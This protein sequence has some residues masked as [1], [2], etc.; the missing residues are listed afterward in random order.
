MFNGKS[1]RDI[2][3]EVVFL[4]KTQNGDFAKKILKSLIQLN[5]IIWMHQLIIMT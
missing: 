4:E 5:V 2:E 1:L 3:N